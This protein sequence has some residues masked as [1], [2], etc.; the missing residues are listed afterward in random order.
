MKMLLNISVPHEPFNTLVK[1]GTAGEL[2]GKILEDIKPEATYFT[3]YDGKRSAILVID[4][5]RSSDIPKFSEPFFL[6]FNADCKFQ[7]LMSPADLKNAGLEQ[8]G[9]KWS[10]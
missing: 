1:K 5:A 6:N 3:E 4:V 7:I 8:L 10:K 9:K 2:L